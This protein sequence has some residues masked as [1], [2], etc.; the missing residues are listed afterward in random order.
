MKWK[1]R[2]RKGGGELGGACLQGGV[3]GAA[4]LSDKRGVGVDH[5]FGLTSFQVKGCVPSFFIRFIK[6]PSSSTR[7]AQVMICPSFA[8]P[9]TMR[10]MFLVRF[11]LLF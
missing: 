8:A 2:A 11:F 3:D 5:G 4:A 9:G 7:Y 6:Q 10:H 1:S